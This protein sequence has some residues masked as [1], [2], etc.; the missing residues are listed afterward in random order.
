MIQHEIG[1]TPWEKLGI[2]L[3]EIDG[4]QLLVVT[5]YY[6]SYISVARLKKTSTTETNQQLM[7]LFAIHGIPQKIV[8]DNGPQFR[9]E[10]EKFAKEL[11]IEII[12][13]SPLYPKSNGKAESA[14]NIVKS[15]RNAKTRKKAN[16]CQY[17]IGTTPLVKKKKYYQAKHCSVGKLEPYYQ[18]TKTSLYYEITGAKK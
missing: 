1:E 16:N 5:D 3:C 14:V 9:S 8:S 17:W 10:Y 13:S 2:D 4:R 11:D 15:L 18:Y 12:H 6:S 7:N